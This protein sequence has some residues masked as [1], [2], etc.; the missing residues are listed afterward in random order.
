M[1]IEATCFA[2]GTL[3][4]TDSHTVDESTVD[5]KEHIEVSAIA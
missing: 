5:A 3:E 2:T 1:A 4:S